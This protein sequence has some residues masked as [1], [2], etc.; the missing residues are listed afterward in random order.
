MTSNRE[1]NRILIEL[2]F[3]DTNA[4]PENLADQIIAEMMS[5]DYENAVEVFDRYFGS[6]VILER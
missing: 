4:F 6:F 1:Q 3:A 2:G 5:S